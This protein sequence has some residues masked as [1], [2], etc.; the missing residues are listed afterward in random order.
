MFDISD[1]KMLWL[2][3]ANIALGIL[4]LVCWV[5]VGYRLVQE[6]L[7]RKRKSKNKPVTSD[8]HTFLVPGLGVTMA[9]GGERVDRI[10]QT[11]SKKKWTG[12]SKS[13]K[14]HNPNN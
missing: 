3:I 12:G 9:D 6:V 14:K 2:N 7:E 1:P 4:T 11:I 5:L 8:D 10:S 13:D